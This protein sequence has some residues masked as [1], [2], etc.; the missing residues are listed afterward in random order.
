MAWKVLITLV[1]LALVGFFALKHLPGNNLLPNNPAN[2]TSQNVTTQN[3]D[4]TL[5]QT[6][7]NINQGM[8]QLDKDLQD[9]DATGGK[10]D[11][12]NSL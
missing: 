7:A 1:I 11:D 8:D 9:V 12:P 5:S 4:D 6:D 10:E 2:Q 3:A